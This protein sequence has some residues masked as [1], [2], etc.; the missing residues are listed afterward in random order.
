MKLRL[1]RPRDEAAVEAQVEPVAHDEDTMLP[2]PFSFSAYREPRV[3]VCGNHTC[4]YV[5]RAT[6]T[7]VASPTVQRG[8]AAHWMRAMVLP[9]FFRWLWIMGRDRHETGKV[10]VDLVES[11]RGSHCPVCGHRLQASCPRC[12]MD[13]RDKTTT[14][15]RGCGSKF[16]WVRAREPESQ[17]ELISDWR[18]KSEIVGTTPRGLEVLV[19]THSITKIAI[20]GIVSGDA[21]DGEMRGDAAEAIAWEA[22]IAEESEQQFKKLEGTNT[23]WVTG[24]GKLEVRHIIHVKVASPTGGTDSAL[25]TA[26]VER[27]MKG[28]DE[29]GLVTLAFP[30]L[31]TGTGDLTIK[32]SAEAM[33]DAFMKYQRDPSRS[34]ALQAVLV[35]LYKGEMR[36]EF[37]AALSGRLATTEAVAKRQG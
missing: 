15:C 18:A 27:A 16:P 13:L 9:A 3:R 12:S 21:S 19:T 2:S 17:V 29:Q 37:V 33:A 1:G 22:G 31:G 8:K 26:A 34:H 6:L 30:A 10:R 20:D 36:R 14:R 25:I 5:E 11:F 32:A 24:P 7:V 35:V 23:A 4:S 28:A